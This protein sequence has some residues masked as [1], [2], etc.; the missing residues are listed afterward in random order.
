[1][2]RSQSKLALIAVLAVIRI[3]TCKTIGIVVDRVSGKFG[4]KPRFAFANLSGRVFTL[5]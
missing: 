3:V 4:K 2:S 5:S 1:M